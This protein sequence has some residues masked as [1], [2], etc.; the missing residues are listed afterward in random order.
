L[1][2]PFRDVT[3]L[4]SSQHRL[5]ASELGRRIRPRTYTVAI[6]LVGAVVLIQIG[7][8]ISIFWLRA[9]VVSVRVELP[10][11]VPNT[12]QTSA[13]PLP[14]PAP[15]SLTP[16]LPR[17][18]MAPT[19]EPAL[20]SV[21][22][23]SGRLEQV[24]TLN[25]EAQILLHQNDLKGAAEV[26]NRAE[27]IDPSNPTTLKNSAET[28]YLMNDSVQAK[29][30]WQRLVDLGPGVGTVYTLAK[31]HVLLLASTAEA[32]ALVERSPLP[33]GIYIDKVEK[34]PVDTATGQPQFLLKTVLARKNAKAPFDQK[35]LQPYV[36]F[37]Q[38][39]PNGQLTPDL[40]QHKGSFENTFL[41]WNRVKEPFSVDY[42][43]P[44]SGDPGP[45]DTVFGDYYGFV[46]GIYYNKVLQDTR[47][48]PSDL[49][50]RKPL[51]QAIE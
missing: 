1:A 49:I 6:Y 24:D 17:L 23:E 13:A 21:P 27:D 28:F 44:T 7:M 38:R 34:N 14:P 3:R 46:I 32:D 51:P 29:N 10:K 5:P 43:M 25:E 19:T 30:Y 12:A 35:L 45:N 31:D 22:S 41:F 8:L 16:E 11:A 4:P 50:K 26:L 42:L 37:Y 20:L 36:I 47:S 9:M 48:E 2:P 39:M 33:R 15:A 40:S 18:S